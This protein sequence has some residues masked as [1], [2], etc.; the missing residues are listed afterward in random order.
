MHTL[1]PLHTQIPV[2]NQDITHILC[3]NMHYI[4]VYEEL[5]GYSNI[6]RNLDTPIVRCPNIGI[7]PYTNICIYKRHKTGEFKY[8]NIWI[9]SY[10]GTFMRYRPQENGIVVFW[11][12]APEVTFQ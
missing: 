8:V 12:S 10:A 2:E 11:K 5:F 6:E 1:I 9:C 3:K 4:S 7:C